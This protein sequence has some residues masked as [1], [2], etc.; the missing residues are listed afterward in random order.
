VAVA[1]IGS[2]VIAENGEELVISKT[3]VG[4]SISEGMICDSRMLGWSGGASGIAVQIPADVQLGSVP[5][6]SRPRQVTASPESTIET[7]AEPAPGLFE[8]KL[9]KEEKKKLAEERKTARKAAKEAKGSA[10]E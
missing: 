3:T 5:P 9:T 1:P 8:R 2:T 6:R 7:S 10:E 4:G